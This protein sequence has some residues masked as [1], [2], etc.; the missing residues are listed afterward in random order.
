MNSTPAPLPPGSLGTQRK[1]F[2]SDDGVIG[3]RFFLTS[4]RRNNQLSKEL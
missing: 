4:E 1:K 2:Q 3:Y